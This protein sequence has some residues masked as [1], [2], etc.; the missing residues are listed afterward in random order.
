MSRRQ[1]LCLMGKVSGWSWPDIT[2]PAHIHQPPPPHPPHNHHPRP[3]PGVEASGG[4]VWNRHD[5]DPFP[6][7]TVSLPLTVC[8]DTNLGHITPSRPSLTIPPSLTISLSP[9]S[10][11]NPF[12]KRKIM[13]ETLIRFL[14]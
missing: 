13:I 11:H 1:L 10:T 12:G 4:C 8:G 6:E 3:A 14:S 7:I 5:P 2:R 9:L